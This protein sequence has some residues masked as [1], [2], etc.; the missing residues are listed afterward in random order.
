MRVRPAGAGEQA[1][2]HLPTAPVRCRPVSRRRNR[3]PPGF[4]RQKDRLSWPAIETRSGARVRDRPRI[5][6]A[7]LQFRPGIRGRQLGPGA[8][9]RRT[10]PGRGTAGIHQ[11][12]GALM[13]LIVN[14]AELLAAFQLIRRYSESHHQPGQDDPIPELQPPS[15]GFEEFHQRS[16]Q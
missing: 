5:G 15:D 3:N 12:G 7:S 11:H 16:T 4:S 1:W 8:H 10:A 14:S 6:S 13:Q 2:A 9:R